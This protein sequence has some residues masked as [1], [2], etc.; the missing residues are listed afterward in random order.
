MP[1]PVSMEEAMALLKGEGAVNSAPPVELPVQT[2]PPASNPPASD[3]PPVEQPPATAAAE[4]TP[5]EITDEVRLKAINE[6]WGTEYKSIDEFKSLKSTID[7]ANTLREYKT[8]YEEA[9]QKPK[10]ASPYVQELNNFVAATGI[11]DINVAREI[12]LFEN[13]AEKNPIDALVLAEIIKDPS[14]IGSKDKL[15][16]LFSSQYNTKVDESAFEDDPEG[17]SRAKEAAELEQFKLERAAN[18]AK[19]SINEISEKVKNYKEPEV[20]QS[21]NQEKYEQTKAQWDAELTT[22][23][24]GEEIF[25]TIPVL[26]PVGKDKDG[27]EQ[28]ETIDNIDLTPEQQKSCYQNAIGFALANNL[29]LNEQNMNLAVS[30]EMRNIHAQNLGRIIAKDREAQAAKIKLQ[31]EKEIHN[32]STIQVETPSNVLDPKEAAEK[33]LEEMALKHVGA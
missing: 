23:Y 17:L 27:K 26:V 15:Y 16:K 11:E 24:G 3:T 14:V 13:S 25:K 9:V 6:A 2:D 28:F 18:S 33:R 5:L 1:E 19:A 30:I 31:V 21:Q 7:E 22:K 10:Y 20:P 32:P 12:K 4:P 29:E 8:K